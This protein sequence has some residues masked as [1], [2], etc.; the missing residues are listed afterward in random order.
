M[1]VILSF[2]DLAKVI[3]HL[4]S[5]L[6]VVKYGALHYRNLD[7]DKVV[8]HKLTKGNFDDRMCIY[9]QGILI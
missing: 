1:L 7:M 2:E 8:A 4:I 6:P 5:S 9:H 3:G